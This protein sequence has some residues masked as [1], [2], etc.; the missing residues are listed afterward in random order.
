MKKRIARI[1]TFPSE[2]ITIIS[3][4]IKEKSRIIFKRWNGETAEGI[5]TIIKFQGAGPGILMI[6]LM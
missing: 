4:E 1:G 6:E 5:I 2:P 3:G